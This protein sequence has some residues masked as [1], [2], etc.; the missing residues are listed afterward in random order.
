MSCCGQR[1]TALRAGAPDPGAQRRLYS[2][3]TPARTVAASGAAEWLPL[4]YVGRG[5]QSLRSPKT[6][7]VYYAATAGAEV[8]VHADDVEL[9]LR[10]RL[11]ERIKR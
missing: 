6:D 10:T 8:S 11:F 3:P 4:R 5:A 2:A 9:L 7:R 1:R